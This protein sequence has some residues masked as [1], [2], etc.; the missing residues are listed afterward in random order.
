MMM[1]MFYLIGSLERERERE[2]EERAL[3]PLKLSFVNQNLF[4]FVDNT[5]AV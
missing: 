2:R 3:P 1:V 4:V 5:W